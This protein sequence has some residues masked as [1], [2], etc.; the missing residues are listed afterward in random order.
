MSGLVRTAVGSFTLDQ[1]VELERMTPDAW[2]SHLLPSERAVEKLPHVHLSDAELVSVRLG[3][4]IPRARTDDETN[5]LAAI[6]SSGRLV[7]IL[8]RRTD[9]L[10]GPV[11]NLA[12][13]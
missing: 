4:P 13:P 10:L 12:T 8:R 9:L 3:Q 6:D 11:C 1:A 2:S 5:D 7:A